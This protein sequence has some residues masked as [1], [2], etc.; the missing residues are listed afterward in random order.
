ML[1]DSSSKGCCVNVKFVFDGAK[2]AT[3]S[4]K[5]NISECQFGIVI[6]TNFNKFKGILDLRYNRE[7]I[8]ENID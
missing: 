6:K 1:G 2:I 3:K 4:Q 7:A 8:T 5:L